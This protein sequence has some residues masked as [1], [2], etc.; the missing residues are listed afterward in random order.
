MSGGG[1]RPLVDEP[2]ETFTEPS[3][4]ATQPNDNIYGPSE[5]LGQLSGTDF[6]ALGQSHPHGQPGVVQPVGE[7][8]RIAD[9]SAVD[10][11]QLGSEVVRQG[12]LRSLHAHQSGP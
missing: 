8:P 9:P 3:A 1:A 7:R 6:T 5:N 2:D 4:A 12:V 11:D 10:L